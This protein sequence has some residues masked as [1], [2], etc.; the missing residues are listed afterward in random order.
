MLAQHRADMELFGARFDRWYRE[1]E[2]HAGGKLTA[3]LEKLRRRGMVY[4]TDGATW[5]GTAAAE[6][7]EDDKDRVLVK[8]DG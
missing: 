1:S 6:G 7:S 2:L 4:E 3:V 5:L 8:S